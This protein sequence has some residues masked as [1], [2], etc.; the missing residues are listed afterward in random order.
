MKKDKVPK[1][2]PDQTSADDKMLID[3]TESR[4]SSI[5]ISVPSSEDQLLLK[6]RALTLAQQPKQAELSK[7]FLEVIEFRLASEVYGLETTFV[8]EVLT[9][10]DFTTLPGLPPFVLGIVNVRGQI[11]SVI[12]LKKYFNLP[13]K[14]LGQF[15]I[16]IILHNEK[17][18]FGIL[19]DEVFSTQSIP[20]DAIQTTPST[21]SGIVGE[22]LRGVTSD[23]IIILDGNKILNDNRIT[24]NQEMDNEQ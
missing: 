7:E 18:E 2:I 16:L 11:F 5:P 8:Q 9:L 20:L 3:S 1:S 10:K 4:V 13:E 21:V 19:V 24:V 12:N 15:N 14:G 17:M 22:Y 6:T 23:F